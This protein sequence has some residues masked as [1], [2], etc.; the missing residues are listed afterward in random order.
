LCWSE[1]PRRRTGARRCRTSFE[2][3]LRKY[4]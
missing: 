2:S 1:K 3:L 4:S